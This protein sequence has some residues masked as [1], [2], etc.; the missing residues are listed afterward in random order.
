MYKS[1]IFK[2]PNYPKN[3]QYELNCLLYYFHGL[4]TELVK[5]TFTTFNLRKPI[6]KKCIDYLDMFTT[7]ESNDQQITNNEM[8]KIPSK[9]GQTFYNLSTN[10]SRPADYRLCGDLNDFPQNNF[11]SISSI[12]LLIFHTASKIPGIKH[13]QQMGFIGQFTFDLKSNYQ[14]NG[15][16]KENTLCDYEFHY[17]KLLNHTTNY[18]NFFSPYYPSNYP[19]NIKCRFI[20]KANKNQRIIL[21][22][23]S[24]Q[25][26]SMKNE[27]SI[28]NIER[29]AT[30]NS[31][32][33]HN[34]FISIS[35]MYKNKS[36]TLAYL[37]TNLVNIQLVSH[38]PILR[39]D[40]ISRS[41]FYQGQGFHGTYEFV[42]ESQVLPSPFL[43]EN[44]QLVET[45][46]HEEKYQN[47]RNDRDKVE[48]F[49]NTNKSRLFFADAGFTSTRNMQFR[50]DEYS[51]VP[52][53][54]NLQ[55]SNQFNNE[56]KSKYVRK[57]LIISKGPLNRTQGII[58][59]PQF[60]EPY[61]PSI[62]AMYT[63]IGQPTEIILVKFLFLELGNSNSCENENKSLGDRI[64][65]FDGM[66]IE[67][68]LIIEYCENKIVFS[69]QQKTYTTFK[70]EYFNSSKN[71]M[72]L[73]F[74]SDQIS[75]PD[76][77]GFRLFYSFE[78]QDQSQKTAYE[79]EEKYLPI[80]GQTGII[81]NKPVNCSKFKFIT[82]ISIIL[83]III[84]YQLK[85]NR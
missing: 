58:H 74:K 11:Y 37:C 39:L 29:C 84:C 49:S 2:T 54:M 8:M 16:H 59:S 22:F 83:P 18:G 38:S 51:F 47:P 40:F 14:N 13:N 42:H 28:Y 75:R 32:P 45:N 6:E 50:E 57:K 85:E 71:L 35:E 3:Y 73:R 25:L 61:P 26:K 19:P 67:D 72:T 7:I 27:D 44:D 46:E 12:L 24:I 62:I 56:M 68:P 36:R 17:S 31:I 76:E 53:F 66:H 10:S 15:K 79:E 55:Y 48:K 21:T 5:I 33:V 34:D 63:F 78:R 80:T 77:L 70:P 82:E 20:F 52:D 41:P 64:Q 69:N 1:G 81:Q 9:F 23:H 4:S 65:L 30:R 43:E 60:P